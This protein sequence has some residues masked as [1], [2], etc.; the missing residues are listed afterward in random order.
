MPA[1]YTSDTYAVYTSTSATI[2]QNVVESGTCFSCSAG[3]PKPS[4]AIT[5]IVGTPRKKSAY[6]MP[7]R[8]RGNAAGPG[9]LRT[10][11][12]SS[13]KTR[14]NTSAMEKIFTFNRNA[15]EISG[16]ELLN[17]PQSKKV[18]RTSCQPGA[19]VIASASSVKTATVLRIAIEI[20]RRPSPPDITLPRILEPR[21]SFSALLQDGRAAD[22]REPLVLD[23]GQ[24]PVRLQLRDRLVDATHER[25]PLLEDHAE[26][27]TGRAG[28][29]LAHDHAVR[30]L[31]GR[32]IEGGRQID[33]ECVGLTVL[34]R[35]DGG[36]VGVED[37]GLLRRLDLGLDVLVARRADLDAELV[38]LQVG[39]RLRARDLRA[40][41]GND[42]R[43]A[44]V[45]GTPEVGHV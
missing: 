2:P 22:L 23:L 14:M 12:S 20:A 41:L 11:A 44:V 25:V 28:R 7:S 26:V 4:I 5:R 19:C 10:T 34:Q 3:A 18:R 31:R 38:R 43:V 30:H 32:D 1:R 35:G 13:A 24:R 21:F 16:S 27:L 29:E 36:V 33:D 42:A 37:G 6:A 39:N 17:C 15:R 8:R 45:L 40:L 9:R